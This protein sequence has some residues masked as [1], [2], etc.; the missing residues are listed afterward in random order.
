[1]EYGAQV[2]VHVNG[3]TVDSQLILAARSEDEFFSD[4]SW[5]HTTSSQKYIYVCEDRKQGTMVTDNY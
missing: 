1:M 2:A 3:I 5:D 4:A